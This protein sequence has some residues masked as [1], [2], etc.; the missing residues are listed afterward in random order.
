MQ[1]VE[2]RPANPPAHSKRVTYELRESEVQQPARDRPLAGSYGPAGRPGRDRDAPQPAAAADRPERT[3][4]SRT[5]VVERKAA[6]P[7]RASATPP[8][9]NNAEKKYEREVFESRVVEETRSRSRS[10]N[11][12]DLDRSANRSRVLENRSGSKELLTTPSKRARPEPRAELL[13]SE[14]VRTGEAFPRARE[15]PAAEIVT[16]EYV[17][18]RTTFLGAGNQDSKAP[19]TFD[20]NP[21]KTDNYSSA[22]RHV[23]MSYSSKK[24]RSPEWSKAS[25]Y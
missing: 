14:V 20:R 13:R 22:S 24:E 7:V 9:A 21:S 15:I 11:P 23:E 2:E 19:L 3:Q 10:R 5:T 25:K 16:E 4:Y 17:S 12:T 6:D 1:N 18:K 8:P